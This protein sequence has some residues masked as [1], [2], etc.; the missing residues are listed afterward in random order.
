MCY[1]RVCTIHLHRTITVVLLL[2]LLLAWV[3]VVVAVAV[4]VAVCRASDTL[5]RAPEGAPD[6]GLQ[7]GDSMLVRLRIP[8]SSCCAGESVYGQER[9]GARL[10]GST[11]RAGGEVIM[12]GM[13][14]RPSATRGGVQSRNRRA[15]SCGSAELHTRARCS[16]TIASR[17]DFNTL[18]NVVY[19]GGLLPMYR[20]KL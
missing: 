1:E 15:T 13:R 9:D 3:V 6:V 4:V 2:L 10:G 17:T 16:A 18:V 11:P 12:V 19:M 7:R 5:A 14:E 8:C 20:K